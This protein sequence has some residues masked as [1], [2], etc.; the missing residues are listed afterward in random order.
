ML[1]NKYK[2]ISLGTYA[3]HLL[4]DAREDKLN[5]LIATN[6]GYLK[7][8]QILNLH[9]VEAVQDVREKLNYNAF[10]VAKEDYEDDK[11]KMVKY[12]I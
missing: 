4:V 6:Q 11:G 7:I 5:L 2:I 3:T 12:Q 8:F 10:R 9:E 1:D